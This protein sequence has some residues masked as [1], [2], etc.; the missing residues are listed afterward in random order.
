MFAR[1]L[2]PRN[3]SQLP[4][5]RNTALRQIHFSHPPPP[6]RTSRAPLRNPKHAAIEPVAFALAFTLSVTAAYA[7]DRY[8]K[9]E[10]PPEPLNTPLLDQDDNDDLSLQ[11]QKYP[12]VMASQQAP[13]RP[14]NLTPEEQ[15][16]LKE[17]GAGTRDLRR[18]TRGN[19]Q[20]RHCDTHNRCAARQQE[21]Q[22]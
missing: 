21:D 18:S 17:M 3:F 4:S 15:V 11:A 16:K 14:G 20:Q 13:G 22:V 12:D 9:E 8:T 10:P 1:H 19:P 5:L 6:L 2:R 7:L